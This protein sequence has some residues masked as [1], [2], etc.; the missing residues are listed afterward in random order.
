MLCIGSSLTAGPPSSNCRAHSCPPRWRVPDWPPIGPPPSHA[1][2]GSCWLRGLGWMIGRSINHS[3]LSYLPGPLHRLLLLHGLTRNP[4]PCSPCMAARPLPASTDRRLPGSLDSLLL[5]PGGCGQ[6]LRCRHPLWGQC[7]L[8][9]LP[10]LVRGL[11]LLT[12]LGSDDAEHGRG[13]RGQGV[14]RGMPEPELAAGAVS[15]AGGARACAAARQALA[16]RHTFPT[17][18]PWCPPCRWPA[19]WPRQRQPSCAAH[20][21]WPSR[22][23]WVSG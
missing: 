15:T 7:P 21:S 18:Q 13:Q 9:L 10:Q 6:P 4:K 23:L 16:H 5:L 1:A 12:V 14:G 3:I 19:T 22:L 8:P 11:C 2:H 20:S 17:V